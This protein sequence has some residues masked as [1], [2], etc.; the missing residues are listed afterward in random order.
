MGYLKDFSP[1]FSRPTQILR[2]VVAAPYAL[3]LWLIS[4]FI[5]KYVEPK[6]FRDR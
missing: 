4:I 1:G 2:G 6:A 3:P 5:K